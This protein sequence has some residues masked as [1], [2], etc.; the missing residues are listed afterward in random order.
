[1]VCGPK[2]YYLKPATS[3]KR[4]RATAN[5]EKLDRGVRMIGTVT[6]FSTCTSLGGSELARS[7]IRETSKC[8]APTLSQSGAGEGCEVES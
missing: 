7:L 2:E 5:V 4:R 1:M 8:R 3:G 6:W